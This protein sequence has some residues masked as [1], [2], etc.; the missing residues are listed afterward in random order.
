MALLCGSPAVSCVGFDTGPR[1]GG[2]LLSAMRMM[3]CFRDEVHYKQTPVSD[4]DWGAP[5]NGLK[6][7]S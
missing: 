6:A 1:L 3:K 5:Q 4:T 2:G 7:P